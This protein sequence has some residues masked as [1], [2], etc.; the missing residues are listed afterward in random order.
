MYRR[1]LYRSHSGPNLA[2]VDR[3]KRSIRGDCAGWYSRGASRRESTIIGLA[4]ASHLRPNVV[5]TTSR[6][7]DATS[8]DVGSCA[9]DWGAWSRSAGDARVVLGDSRHGDT[10]PDRCSV[11][12]SRSRLGVE[13]HRGASTSVGMDQPH[14]RHRRRGTGVYDRARARAGRPVAHGRG[15]EPNRSARLA[16]PGSVAAR[17]SDGRRCRVN[18][19]GAHSTRW[20]S[21]RAAHDTAACGPAVGRRY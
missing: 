11:S 4:G 18:V 7:S 17:G 9:G 8:T 10:R 14:S 16:Q 19:G 6:Q 13:R 5:A 12:R 21:R 20:A 3:P 15:R 2:T 1:S